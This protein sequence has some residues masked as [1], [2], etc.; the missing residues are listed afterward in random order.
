MKNW[1]KPLVFVVL[2][3]AIGVSAFQIAFKGSSTAPL[4][5]SCKD[6]AF[7]LCYAVSLDASGCSNGAYLEYPALIHGGAG[8]LFKAFS[9]DP[10]FSFS[11]LLA[12][13][14]VFLALILLDKGGIIAFSLF[15]FI[16]PLFLLTLFGFLG[17]PNDPF[18]WPSMLWCGAVP[19]LVALTLFFGLFFYKG[20]FGWVK[21]AFLAIVIF[22]VHSWGWALIAL[23]VL[24][25]VLTVLPS[26]AVKLPVL[27]PEAWACLLIGGFCFLAG[28][29]GWFADGL[30]IV[31]A[32]YFFLAVVAANWL[33]ESFE[34]IT[35]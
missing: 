34:W 16:I 6:W 17:F 8:Y 1:L 13:C 32:F 24:S 33:R 7:H 19:F 18:T 26:F 10:A 15:F 23:F 22:L 9:V 5:E 35:I 3:V 11:V 30:R 31:Y 4:V 2:A 14:F 27:K 20:S 29:T 21:K 12:V 28:V 25:H